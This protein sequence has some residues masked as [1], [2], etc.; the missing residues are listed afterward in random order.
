MSDNWVVQNLENAL[1]T[2]NEKLAEIWQLLTQSPEN[3]K[4]G[5]I[6]NVIKTINGTVQAI[7]LALLVLFFVVGIVKTCG[8]FAE[9]KKPEVAIKLFVRFALAKAVVTYGLELMMALFSIVQGVISTIMT[10]AG[11]GTAQQTVL[12]AE[13]VTAIEDCGFWESIPLWAVAF[14]SRFCLLSWSSRYMAAFFACISTRPLPRFPF[15]PLRGN[16][17]SKLAGVF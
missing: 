11:M 7:G 10:A 12:P 4:G 8:S 5:T 15:R 13:I 1:E 6:W 14:L 3:F 16:P 2:W 17:S 9:V